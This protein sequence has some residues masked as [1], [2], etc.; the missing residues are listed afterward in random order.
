MA[1]ATLLMCT[2]TYD[3]YVQ[4]AIDSVRSQRLSE[5]NFLLIANSVDDD[6]YRILS[7]LMVS[8]GCKIYRTEMQGLTFSLNWGLHLATTKYV[9]RMDADDICY[10]DRILEQINFMEENPKVVVCGGAYDLIDESGQI[11]QT[12]ILPSSDKK[13]RQAL[14]WGNPICHPTVILRRDIALNVGGYSGDKS[15]DYELWLKLASNH[16]NKFF[17]FN[18]AFIGYRTPVKS[19]ARRS[20]LAYV[21][22]FLAQNRQ[23]FLTFNPVWVISGLF[24]LLKLLVRS[25]F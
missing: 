2:N 13:I 9:I 3:E 4:L 12:T 14:Y 19:Q 8:D 18:K 5:V 24:T 23:F 6:T 1:I 16:E 7:D 17:N 11:L 15:E 21:N 10:P 20:P 22:V 25:R